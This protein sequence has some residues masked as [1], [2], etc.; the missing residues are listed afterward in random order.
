MLF[1]PEDE[2]QLRRVRFVS[3]LRKLRSGFRSAR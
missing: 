3:S 2:A 1:R